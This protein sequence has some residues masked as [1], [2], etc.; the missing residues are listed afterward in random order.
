[1][2]GSILTMNTSNERL[3]KELS[4]LGYLK[5]PKLAEAMRTVLREDFVPEEYRIQAYED[6]P[7]PIGH[8]QTTSQPLVILFMLE[9]LSL[10]AGDTV[11]EIGTGS[12]WQT[13]LM[14]CITHPSVQQ[15][16]AAPQKNIVSIERIPELHE[17]AVSHAGKYPEYAEHI[18]F[19]QGDGSR[20]YEEQ[21]PFDRIICGAAT[22]AVP[23]QWKDQVK[24]GGRIVVPE[25]ECIAVLEKTGK[26]EF[27]R[28][29]FF[30]FHFVPLVRE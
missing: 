7:L 26:N 21:A 14:A 4:E 9:L 8:E 29:E 17:S 25:G 6:E 13:V 27:S 30:G 15:P 22:D 12:G 18:S 2:Y 28:K 23:Q 1:M 11:L 19:L 5:S 3:I 16:D 24:I 10:Q 20:G